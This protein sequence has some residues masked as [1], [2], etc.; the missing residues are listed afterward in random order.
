MSAFSALGEEEI[1][2][3]LPVLVIVLVAVATGASAAPLAPSKPSD[4]R[5]VFTDTQTAC[6]GGNGNVVTKTYDADGNVV[7]FVIPPKFVFVVTQIDWYVDGATAS[8][9]HT[10]NFLLNLGGGGQMTLMVDGATA[11]ANGKIRKTTLTSPL[12]VPSGGTICA[13]ASSGSH[14]AFV[15]G[16]VTK[17][18]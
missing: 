16:F 7:P 1:V 15:H 6:P 4:I 11:D 3:L 12:I 13:R 9:T 10:L 5:M 14:G 18:K 8:Q 17:A 2:K